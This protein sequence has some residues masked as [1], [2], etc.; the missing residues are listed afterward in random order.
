MRSWEEAMRRL[1][2]GLKKAACI[3]LVDVAAA[4]HVGRQGGLDLW[5][6]AWQIAGGSDE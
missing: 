2:G 1:T 3:M 4:T 6:D 5:E